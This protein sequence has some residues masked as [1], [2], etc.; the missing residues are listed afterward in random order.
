MHFT[1]ERRRLVKML[2]LVRRKLP[3]QKV[4][5]K[6]V[7][8]YACAA[9]VFVDANGVTGGEEALVFRNGSCSIHLEGFLGLLKSYSSKPNVTILVD[10]KSLHLFSSALTISEFTPEAAPPGDF[11]VGRVIDDLFKGDVN[12][13]NFEKP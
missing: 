2:E 5:D 6:K 9:R 10:E 13:L 12:R 8:L 4:K 1:I 3:G 7:R 11:L